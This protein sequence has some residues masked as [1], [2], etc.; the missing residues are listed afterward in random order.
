MYF[1]RKEVTDELIESVRELYIR[2][3]LSVKQVCQQ[4]Q[5]SENQFFQIRKQ[6]NI[7]RLQRKSEILKRHTIDEIIEYFQTH[8]RADTA[9]HFG[10]TEKN[11]K[12]LMK[13]YN[14]HHTTEQKVAFRENTCQKMYG[15]KCVLQRQDVID[16]THSDSALAKM[17]S[18][19]RKNNLERYGVEYS[20]EREDVKEKTKKTNLERYGTEKGWASTDEGRKTI[21]EIHSDPEYQKKE[22]ESKRRNN[23]FNKSNSEEDFYQ[24]LLNLFENDDVHR[25]YRSD[26][27]PFNCDFYIKSIDTYIECNFHWTHGK[28]PFDKDSI[29]CQEKLS[30][31]KEKAESSEFY[32]CAIDVWTRRDVEKIEYAVENGINIIFIYPNNLIYSIDAQNKKLCKNESIRLG[33]NGVMDSLREQFLS[34][35]VSLEE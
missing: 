19:Q 9:E 5:I 4:L 7:T 8:T 20:W 25:Q 35:P 2:K 29:V 32:K 11:L 34:L 31:W 27:Y 24:L 26:K 28:I 23:S 6:Y 21:S 10:I 15:V 3:R 18:T 1:K 30:Q 17:I 16:K 12:D 14:F 13:E 22:I 33:C